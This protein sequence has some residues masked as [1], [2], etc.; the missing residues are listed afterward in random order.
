MA[1]LD[2]RRV[3]GVA[4]V[5][6]VLELQAELQTDIHTAVVAPLISP[7]V[8]PPIPEVNPLVEADG[9]KLAVRLEQMLSFPKSRLGAKVGNLLDQEYRITRAVERLLF[10]S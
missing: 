9:E 10:R 3:K 1:R 8:L 4:G 6:L 5:A 2:V 7:L